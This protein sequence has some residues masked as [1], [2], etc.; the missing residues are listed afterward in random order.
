VSI[1]KNAGRDGSKMEAKITFLTHRP[2]AR[3][4]AGPYH[5]VIHLFEHR[6]DD[7]VTFWY[8]VAEVA[9]TLDDLN[10]DVIA[11]GMKPAE[12]LEF[13]PNSFWARI[14]LADGRQGGAILLTENYRDGDQGQHS[15]FSFIGDSLLR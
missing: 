7:A 5:A 12:G 4:V 10:R 9:C 1:E 14:E 11:S 13:T 2:N 15:R 6:Y 3:P 8:G